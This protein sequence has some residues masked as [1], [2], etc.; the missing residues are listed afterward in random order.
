MAGRR[1][2]FV[3]SERYQEAI[4]DINTLIRLTPE[5]ADS[6]NRQIRWLEKLIEK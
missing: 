1:N 3:R 5:K 2:I 6:Y 4:N